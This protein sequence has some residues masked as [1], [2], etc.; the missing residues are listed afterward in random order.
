[1]IRKIMLGG[2]V[3]GIEILSANYSKYNAQ[4]L[5]NLAGVPKR[6]VT[7]EVMEDVV[8]ESATYD[9]DGNV[10]TPKVT[11]SQ[12]VTKW[13][14]FNQAELEVEKLENSVKKATQEAERLYR[15]LKTKRVIM[16][17]GNE[18]D[19]TDTFEFDF[20]RRAGGSVR[21]K[22]K[23]GKTAVKTKQQT[24]TIKEALLF[25]L[26][27]VADALDADIDAIGNG[28]YSNSNLK[29]L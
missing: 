26:N 5:F 14:F 22:L 7:F 9:D 19:L 23:G 10:I 20:Q 18:Y 13:R 2:E 6:Y 3:Q 25:Y 27:S 24:D 17:G 16:V 29:A 1:M 28:D 21:M 15:E 12:N 11:E 8:I 4:E